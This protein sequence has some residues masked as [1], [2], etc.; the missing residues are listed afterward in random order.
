MA[1]QRRFEPFRV[2]VLPQRQRVHVR[3]F[4][5]LDV[6]TARRAE[7][8]LV[9]LRDAGWNRVVLDFSGLTFVSSTGL[10]LALR[11]TEAAHAEGFELTLI[12]GSPR[13]QRVFEMAGIADELPFAMEATVDAQ[14]ATRG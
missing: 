12:T 8:V 11:W 2:E 6:S 7:R 1:T 10:H 4:G 3:L 13:V 14:V 5:E 9:D